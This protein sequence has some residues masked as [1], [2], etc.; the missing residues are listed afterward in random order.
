[1]IAVTRLDGRQV[2]INADLIESIEQTPDTIISFSSGHKLIVRNPPEDLAQRVIEF[3]RAVLGG[4][5]SRDWHGAEPS[6]GAEGD[7]R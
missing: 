4:A 2:F 1:M 5:L 7:D 6:A 3:R